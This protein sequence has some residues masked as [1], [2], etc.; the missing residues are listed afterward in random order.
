V[1]AHRVAG[2]LV[3]GALCGA[4]APS[5]GQ[6]AQSVPVVQPLPSALTPRQAREVVDREIAL[7]SSTYLL[8]E[9]RASLAAMLRAKE[10]AGAY[11]MADPAVLA[12]RLRVDLRNETHDKHMGMIYAPDEYMALAH[13]GAHGTAP[14]F[15]AA[16]AARVNQGYLELRVLPGNVRYAN[17]INFE[18][19]AQQTPQAVTD[20]ARFLGGGAAVIIDL[21]GNRGGFPGAVRA[22]ISYFLPAKPQRLMSYIDGR[23]QRTITSD[24]II[25][26]DA[27]RLTGK[28]LYVL[29]APAT[30]SA[31]EEFAYHVRA[32]GLGTLVGETTSGAANY[33]RLYPLGFGLIASIST[34]LTVHA[35]T[36]GNW[37][38][39]GIAPDVAVPASQALDQAH[40]LALKKLA[41]LPGADLQDI[42]WAMAYETA[43]LAP[44]ARPDDAA[45]AA[46]AG[47]YGER[48]VT[49]RD[50]VL[51]WKLPDNADDWPMTPIAAD[52]FTVGSD[53]QTRIRF[54]RTGGKIIG[55]DELRAG[56]SVLSISRTP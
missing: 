46:Y 56:G 31:A 52:L 35:V 47:T 38:G 15:V 51:R 26:L 14:D 49:V 5:P 28:P 42:D 25:D 6:S 29:I 21:R 9:K 17:V 54:R 11:D 20:A 50:G 34:T 22:L 44:P 8:A 39:T 23:T 37:E 45:M 24:V 43:R 27:P 12:D 19:N 2:L 41:S 36:N 18:W 33:N 40:W 13:P 16:R 30:A 10:A 55:L 48:V 53:D 7:V 3:V 4:P 1:Q 32:F